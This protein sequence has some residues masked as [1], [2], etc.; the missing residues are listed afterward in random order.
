MLEGD[1]VEKAKPESRPNFCKEDTGEEAMWAHCPV[2]FGSGNFE[3]VEMGS[4]AVKTLGIPQLSLV[5][6]IYKYTP[7]EGLES[8]QNVWN[9]R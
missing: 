3:W 7:K 2:G 5:Y 9:A 1:Q 8:L 4:E 6:I